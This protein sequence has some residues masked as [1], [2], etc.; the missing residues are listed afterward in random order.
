MRQYTSA[1]ELKA[2][3]EALYKVQGAPHLLQCMGI[4]DDPASEHRLGVV[5]PRVMESLSH[6]LA[7]V[8]GDT[9]LMAADGTGVCSIVLQVWR[10]AAR[11]RTKRPLYRC[12]SAAWLLAA[13]AADA[14]S[15]AAVCVAGGARLSVFPAG[16]RVERHG[17]RSVGPR[18][19]A[20]SMLAGGCRQLAHRGS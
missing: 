3:L 6:R 19:R 17:V 1:D 14:C 7:D 5:V 10:H 4:V 8:V 20:R 18:I 9:P 15:R 13:I 11:E 12:E 2:E 16:F